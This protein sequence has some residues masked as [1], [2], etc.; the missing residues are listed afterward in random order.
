MLGVLRNVS[1]DQI[2]AAYRVLAKRYHPDSPNG[3]TVQFRRIGD[4]YELLIDPLRRRE[5]D[6]QHPEPGFGPGETARST[7]S[8]SEHRWDPEAPRGSGET[9]SAP[10]QGGGLFDW[11]AGIAEDPLTALAAES[12][13]LTGTASTSM[14]QTKLKIGFNRAAGLM[15]ELERFGIV[16]PLDPRNPAVPRRIYGP[17]SWLRVDPMDLEPPSS[18]AA[19]SRSFRGGTQKNGRPS[20]GSRLSITSALL[21]VA[22]ILLAATMGRNGGADPSSTSAPPFSLALQVTILRWEAIDASRGYAHV[23][24]INPG[25]LPQTASCLVA[26]GTDFGDAGVGAI[27]ERVAG[28][29]TEYFR[30]PI[31]VSGGAARSV[32][33]ARVESCD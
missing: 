32:S 1:Q 18:S 22:V 12:I 33:T 5:W 23:R 4:A 28:L 13:F 6:A 30:V 26:A 7:R 20:G 3:D 25:Q 21:V 31:T 2:R 24:V 19:A 29:S 16:G 11:L 8:P 17:D 27:S 10:S 15:D 14:L 9:A